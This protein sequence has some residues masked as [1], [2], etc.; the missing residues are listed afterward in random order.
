MRHEGEVEAVAFLRF[1]DD[2]DAALPTDDLI[3]GT[4]ISQSATLGRAVLNDDA[5]IHSLASDVDPALL[6]PNLR[7]VVGGG[8]EIFRGAGVLLHGT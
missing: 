6:K 4:K 5:G 1:R 2:A 8:V 7:A 3:A